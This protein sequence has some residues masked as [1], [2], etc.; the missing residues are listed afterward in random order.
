LKALDNITNAIVGKTG[1]RKRDSNDND[2]N[3]ID[4]SEISNNGGIEPMVRTSLVSLL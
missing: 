1:K 3:E 2:E 4:N